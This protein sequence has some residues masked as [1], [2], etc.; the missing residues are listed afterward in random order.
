MGDVL[1]VALIVTGTIVVVTGP[2]RFHLGGLRISVGSP[3]RPYLWATLVLALRHWRVSHD[4]VLAR[5]AGYPLGKSERRLFGVAGPFSWRVFGELAIATIA[6]GALVVAA[7]WPQMR[8]PYSVPNLGDPLFYT[9]QLAWV[10]HQLP[11]D[12]LHLFDGNMFYPERHALTYSDSFIVPAMMSVPFSWLGIHPLVIYT[13]L[14]L[15]AFVLSGV[16]MFLLVRALTGRRDAAAIAGV[17]FA[18]YPY[19]F[20]HYSHLELQTTMWMPLVLWGLHRTMAR[21][22]LRDGIGT[23]VAFALQTLSSLYYGLFLAIYLVPLGATLWLAR[24]CPLRPLRALAAGITLASVII[25][26]VAAQYIRNKPMLGERARQV[27]R[28]Y[29]A[30]RADYLKPHVRSRLYHA[31]SGNGHRERQLF[32]GLTPV[33]L[34][35]VALW[36]P[37]GAARIGYAVAMAVAFDG[38][39]GVN[40]T[41]FPW[42]RA[43]VGPFRQL[44]VPARFALL[45]GLTLAVLAGYGAARLLERWPRWRIP[46]TGLML[47]LVVIE[48]WPRLQLEPVWRRPPAIYDALSA[49]PPAVLAEFPMASDLQESWRDTRYLYFSTFHW[50][51][52]VNGDSSFFPASHADLIARVRNFPNDAVLRYL[53]SRGVDYVAV[54]GAFYRPDTYRKIVET[55]NARPDLTIRAVDRWEGSESRLYQLHH[56]RD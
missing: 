18:L 45:V 20:E 44:R 24:R 30:N 11:R 54:H 25:A 43:Y 42:L 33:V 29:S 9:W 5:L 35:A 16:T 32:P 14:F 40:G 56:G 7:T 26:P 6:F 21:G 22:R 41:I 48:P 37:L 1:A 31:W 28:V 19:R 3:W 38:S 55:L 2:M 36:P 53:R 12:P 4:S 50:Q 39:L 15:S 23:G 34:S 27:V 13:C 10:A 8:Q 47:A 17:V 46:L 51:K 49:S 52:L